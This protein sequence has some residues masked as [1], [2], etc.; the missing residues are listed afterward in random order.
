MDIITINKSR[1]KKYK[2]II[3]DEDFNIPNFNEYE[4]F[5]NNSYNVN[6]LKEICK[7]YKLK[8]SGNKTILKERIYNYLYK[9]FFCIKIQKN[10][11]KFLI[12][13]YLN[14]IGPGKNY[15]LCR[16]DTDFFTLEN[17]NEI[18]IF[19]F[20]TIKGDDNN[21]WGFN[22][23]SIYNLFLKSNNKSNEEVLNPYTREIIKP[24]SKIFDKIKTLIR[25]S[26][27]YTTGINV[28]INNEEINNSK[29]IIEIK[30]LELFQIMDSHGNYTDINWFRTLNKHQ[31]IK[32]LSE[33]L[34][35]WQ[36]RAQLN[37]NIKKD[38]CQ[39]YGNPFRFI[40][41]NNLNNST[42][43]SLQKNTL[44]VIEQFITKGI[45]RDMCS[46]GINFV[47]CAFTLVNQNAANALPWLY[48]SVAF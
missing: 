32:F 30:S 9:S 20:F 14:L 12:K 19:N 33:L 21:I 34:D 8:V 36:Y 42:L 22:I 1:G 2:K 45:N 3:S 15:K 5:Y 11:R 39:P 48:E 27:I 24:K 17:L 23:I 28:N 13:K 43:F 46:L 31:L 10:I 47:L 38:I 18:D 26:K 25:M 16:N 41:I 35:I 4:I 40:T 29:K 6:L 37:I 44:F 7:Y